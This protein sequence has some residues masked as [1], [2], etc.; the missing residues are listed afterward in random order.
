MGQALPDGGDTYDYIKFIGFVS[1][2]EGNN[3]WLTATKGE[4]L[5]KGKSDTDDKVFLE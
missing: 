4:A 5:V 3:F 1:A 2:K